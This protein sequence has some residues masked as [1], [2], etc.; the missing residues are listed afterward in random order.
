MKTHFIYLF[1]IGL[2]LSAC[3]EQIPVDSTKPAIKPITPEPIEH[4][5]DWLIGNWKRIPQTD[6]LTTLEKW[7]INQ[8]SILAGH[9]I[10]LKGQDTIWQENML[11]YEADSNWTFKVN[12]P[13]NQDWVTFLLSIKSDTSFVVQ[14]PAHDFPKRIH[15]FMNQNK[16]CAIVAN[17]ERSLEYTFEK[18]EQ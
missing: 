16:L 12:T 2:I 8:N 6:S 3:Q 4:E 5:F 10:V 1:L 18:L 13:G 7:E 11:F 17:R 14:N 15:Y 9:G